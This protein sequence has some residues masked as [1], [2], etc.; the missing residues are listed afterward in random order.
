MRNLRAL[1]GCLPLEGDD[2]VDS[3]LILAEE[4]LVAVDLQTPGWPLHRLPYISSIHA[5]SIISASHI[6]NV[7]PSLWERIT[8]A[9]CSQHTHFSPRVRCIPVDYVTSL[10]VQHLSWKSGIEKV[11]CW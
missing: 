5:S 11:L 8:M 3:L 1:F 10:I 9:G 4:E 7:P 2:D 6:K